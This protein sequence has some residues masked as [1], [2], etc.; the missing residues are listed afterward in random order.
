MRTIFANRRVLVE[1][2][3][4]FLIGLVNL[5]EGLRLK[6]TMRE[7]GLYDIVGPDNYALVLGFAFVITSIIYVVQGEQKSNIRESKL[8]EE[9][10]VKGNWVQ[11]TC[12][13]GVL[14]LYA[15]L[16]PTIGYLLASIIFFLLVLII[17]GLSSWIFGFII[18][19]VMAL[20]Y[21]I[22]FCYLLGVTVPR[23]FL[24]QIFGI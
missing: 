20:I 18:S 2:S 6:I 7:S 11:V 8:D 17:M 19:V 5:A 24:E 14:L 23:G 22:L 21:Y 13:V 10:E 4:F 16:I 1:G 12:I 15:I 9:S 3:L